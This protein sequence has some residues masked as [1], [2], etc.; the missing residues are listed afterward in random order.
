MAN[1]NNGALE[2]SLQRLHSL[3]L[4]FPTFPPTFPISRRLSS[5]FWTRSPCRRALP[6]GF[7]LFFIYTYILQ[8]TL[9][10]WLDKMWKLLKMP[11]ASRAADGAAS[12]CGK[13]RVDGLGCRL[14]RF[15]GGCWVEWNGMEGA[16]ATDEGRQATD[17]G[18]GNCFHSMSLPPSFAPPPAAAAASSAGRHFSKICFFGLHGNKRFFKNWNIF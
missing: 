7:S 9:W 5:L 14:C 11:P 2:Q 13:T 3:C 6:A 16:T 15:G 10:G 17:D 4:L 18:G 12:L 1:N 8:S